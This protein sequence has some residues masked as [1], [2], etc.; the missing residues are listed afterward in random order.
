M[1]F[2]ADEAFLEE[3]KKKEVLKETIR[4]EREGHDCMEAYYKAHES[5]LKEEITHLRDKARDFGLHN[6]YLDYKVYELEDALK[7]K[8]VSLRSHIEKEKRYSFRNMMLESRCNML[9]KD[10]VQMSVNA[11]H[12]LHHL[13]EYMKY[14]EHLKDKTDRISQAWIHSDTRRV[15]EIKEVQKT[16]PPE[17]RKRPCKE[18]F[19]VE[20]TKLNLKACPFE[21]YPK[22]PK[23]TELEDA[24]N[25][26]DVVYDMF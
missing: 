10:L 4:V 17:S 20:P 24:Q 5:K 26:P 12:N 13:I 8:K 16:L 11:S 7:R 22:A 6:D 19:S 1:L 23:T 3:E 2:Q 21:T 15:K 9:E 18:A 25:A 14:M